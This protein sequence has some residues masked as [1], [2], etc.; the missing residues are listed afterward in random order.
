MMGG[1][2]AVTAGFMGVTVTSRASRTQ[3]STPASRA[4][5]R[6]PG[7]YT[8]NYHSLLY[9]FKRLTVRVCVCAYLCARKPYDGMCIC[10]CVVSGTMS[11]SLVSASLTSFLI[12]ILVPASFLFVLTIQRGKHKHTVNCYLSVCVFYTYMNLLVF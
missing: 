11:R 9:G 1:L 7:I 5:E 4:A 10:L 12:P 6:G 3:L 2:E 8:R